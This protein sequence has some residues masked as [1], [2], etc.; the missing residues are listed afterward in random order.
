MFSRFVILLTALLFTR[1]NTPR[2]ELSMLIGKKIIFSESLHQVCGIRDTVSDV[3]L[4]KLLI[5]YDSSGCNP[6][7]MQH[8]KDLEILVNAYAYCRDKFSFYV[9]F[10]ADLTNPDEIHELLR[11]EK[12]KIPIYVDLRGEFYRLNKKLIGGIG[13]VSLLGKSDEIVIVGDPLASD[14]MWGLYK[15]TLDNLLANDGV[16][17]AE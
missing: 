7:R 5:Y 15:R 10:A 13:H 17:I 1:C 9:I 2:K 14:E 8:L 3:S 6:C 11:R 12:V 4:A 16:Y